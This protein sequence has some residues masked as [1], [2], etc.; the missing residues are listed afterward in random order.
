MA[1]R[2][3]SEWHKREDGTIEIELTQGKVALIDEQ[4]LPKVLPHVW[5]A[6]HKGNCWYAA[7]GIATDSH[8]WTNLRM[9][10]LILY[11]PDGM[12]I[13]HINHNG[14]D[15]R[16]CN[17]RLATHAQNIA[18]QTARA[19]TSSQYKGVHRVKRTC[20]LR[21][22]WRAYCGRTKLGYFTTEREAARAYNRAAKRRYGEFA[23]LNDVE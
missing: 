1:R 19:G 15:N 5:C 20:Q 18:N 12:D 3:H 6:H 10:R 23:L 14:L 2:N 4:D 21:K 13:D 11:A 16:R 22:P 17:L 8:K 9:H 7:T